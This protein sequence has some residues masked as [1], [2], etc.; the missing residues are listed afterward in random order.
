MAVKTLTDLDQT[1]SLANTDITHVRQGLVDKKATLNLL[2]Q[3]LFQEALY[4]FDAETI[5]TNTTITEITHQRKLFVVDTTAG[6]ISLT[7]PFNG[8]GAVGGSI[9]Y[10]VNTGTHNATLTYKDGVFITI[11]AGFSAF[12]MLL[13]SSAGWYILNDAAR[14]IF[15]DYAQFGDAN[16]PKLKEAAATQLALRNAA[17]NAYATLLTGEP[18]Q[19]SEAATKNYVDSREEISY[20]VAT[21]ASIAANDVVRMLNGGIAKASRMNAFPI[22]DVSTGDFSISPMAVCMLTATT[23]V[24]VCNIAPNNYGRA[25]VFTINTNGT[26]SL[27]T[28]FVFNSGTTVM[29][30]AA[31]LSA[32]QVM[33]CYKNGGNSDYGTAIILSISGT[34]IT[35][36]SPFVF[37]S[38]VTYD[39][40]VIRLTDT[41]ALVAYTGP[42]T[43]YYAYACVLSVSGTT[44]TGGTALAVTAVK[45]WQN[46]LAFLSSTKAVLTYVEDTTTTD[47]L[48]AVVLTISGTTITKGTDVS[49]GNCR[50]DMGLT[51]CALSD[52][53]ALVFYSNLVS[54]PTF[55]GAAVILNISG[56]TITAGA[57]Y[58]VTTI[59]ISWEYVSCC[60]F[61][62]NKVLAYWSNNTN[63]L[64]VL[65][66][67][68]F[69]TFV[70]VESDVS[71]NILAAAPI[72]WNSAAKIG[73]GQFVLGYRDFNEGSGRTRLQVLNFARDIM[74][75]A[76]ETK[77]AGQACKVAIGP[78]IRNLTGLTQGAVYYL[79]DLGNF[80][81]SPTN[82]QLGIA[83]STTELLL[84]L[85]PVS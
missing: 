54:S 25:T 2:A 68:V 73:P 63:G 58:T 30:D 66:L 33:V 43:T 52:S 81:T 21:G 18:T 19:N 70:K 84:R 27:G 83:L 75:I 78:K 59:P 77:S 49:I 62:D 11:P 17:D 74:G 67:S 71:M 60:K 6:D 24:V 31:A 40:S 48:H 80:T 4:G 41:S 72:Y 10:V 34:T 65:V 85:A 20:T 79:D 69:D 7:F 28:P 32:T 47:V 76:M 22:T 5:S 8:G 57:P 15:Q 53:K 44:I 1:L 12:L 35:A 45:S 38:A 56:T 61:D 16:G 13:S 3:H 50:N 9:V 51:I 23:G 36:G 39:I 46:R 14:H 64:D 42:S 29:L 82:Y 26:I 55:L 37:A